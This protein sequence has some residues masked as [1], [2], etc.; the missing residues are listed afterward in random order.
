ML[1]DDGRLVALPWDQKVLRSMR[2][3]RIMVSVQVEK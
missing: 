1:W 3:M 2:S